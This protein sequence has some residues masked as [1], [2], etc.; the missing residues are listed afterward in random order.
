MTRGTGRHSRPE[1]TFIGHSTDRTGPPI[2]LLHLLRWLESHTDATARVV[3]LEGGHLE[4]EFRKVAQL[5]VIGEPGPVRVRRVGDQLGRLRDELRS[6]RLRA[7]GPRSLIYVNTAWSIRGLRY[8]ADH[9]GPVVA[10]VH[11]LDTG[12]D[13]HLSDDDRHVLLTRPVHWIA[14]SKAVADN[15]HHRWGVARESLSVHYEMID[16]ASP[17]SIPASEVTSLRAT[18][19]AGPD[20]YVVGTT[21][22]VNWRK[23]PDLFIELAAKVLGAGLPDVHFVWVGVT[24]GSAEA[25]ALQRNAHRAG[26]ADRVHL[27]PVTARPE[28]WMRAFDLFVLPAREDAYPLAVL[29]AA[30]AGR[31]TVCFSAGGMPEFVGTDAG[32]VIDFPNV[33]KMAAEVRALG[34]DPM[35][36]RQLGATARQRVVERHHTEVAAP[37]LW[38]EIRRWVEAP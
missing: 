8:L 19:G 35:R 3:S 17:T 9:R 29:E 24:P 20:S 26:V 2:Y 33:D 18:I 7:V 30:A 14:A 37:L 28:A 31:P 11:E 27:V 1:V 6:A 13:Y 15:L 5:T 36:R 22:V 4:P 10:H 16:A 32:A 12:L 21:A 34:I 23:A 25:Q 38:S